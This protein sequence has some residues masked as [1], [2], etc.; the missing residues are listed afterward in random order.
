[1]P[2][3]KQLYSYENGEVV[4]DETLAESSSFITLN[5]GRSAC[6]RLLSTTNHATLRWI[7]LNTLLFTQADIIEQQYLQ[8]ERFEVTNAVPH[9]VAPEEKLLRLPG[10]TLSAASQAE[11]DNDTDQQSGT[12]NEVSTISFASFLVGW[13]E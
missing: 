11:P 4:V 5:L 1:M 3:K 7:K 10:D 9:G 6:D 8:A 13:F 12:N 2:P